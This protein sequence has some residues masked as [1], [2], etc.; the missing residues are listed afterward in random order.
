MAATSWARPRSFGMRG[1]RPSRVRSPDIGME[2]R[3]ASLGS[4]LCLKPCSLIFIEPPAESCRE[5]LAHATK[6]PVAP[7]PN[8]LRSRRFWITLLVLLAANVF[9][10]NVLLAPAQPTTI[11]LP[12]NV[13]KQQVTEDNVITVTTTGDAITGVTKTAVAEP[14]TG[15]KA[16]HFTTQHPS[17]A[18]D[19][20]ETLLEQHGVPINAKPENPPLPFWEQLLLS[21]GPTLL[22][23]LGLMYLIRRSA[24]AGA[25][26]L[27]GSFGQ[28]R[29]RVY[30]AERPATTFADVAGIDEVKAELLEVVDFLREPEKYRRL[31]GSVPK[32]VLLIGAPGTG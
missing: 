18:S 14:G 5:L 23:V 6:A 2:R 24:S 29:A 7:A 31:G 25:G 13:F 16:T 27:L 4:S 26:G 19:G 8:P 10:T 22:I 3:A 11:T 32:G 9:I 17:F 12:Y 28:S 30:D 21:F 20:L 1:A 15:T